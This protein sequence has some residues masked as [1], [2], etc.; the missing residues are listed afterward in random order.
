MNS[1][2]VILAGLGS[3]EQVALF[4]VGSRLPAHLYQFGA[5][6]LSVL[7]PT[8]SQHHSQGDTAQLRATFRNAY[9]VCL[10]GFV[11]VATF[12]AICARALMETWQAGLPEGSSG[13]RMA[14]VF[15][16]IDDRDVAQ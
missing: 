4:G 13:A 10:T 1:E 7:L 12:G 16:V 6:G 15:G 5:R 9:R 3:F 14:A 2:Q 8:F 11:P